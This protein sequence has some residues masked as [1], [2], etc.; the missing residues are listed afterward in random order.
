MLYA[1]DDLGGWGSGNVAFTWQEYS[2]QRSNDYHTIQER[3]TISL[4]P[5]S[6]FVD[7]VG[8]NVQS[9]SPQVTRGGAPVVSFDSPASTTHRFGWTL[10]YHDYTYRNSHPS[11]TS[12]SSG[13]GGL[14]LI[15]NLPIPILPLTLGSAGLWTAIMSVFLLTASELI[16]PLY[17][18][19][20]VLINRKRL[21]IAAFVLV[22]IFLISTAYQIFASQAL[23][24]K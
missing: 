5:G 21:R 2:W 10:F 17:S 20:G 19:T 1:L 18:K 8:S 24:S 23:I 7:I 4:P 12:N 9:L 15:S 13:N 16:S 14:A 11:P 6:T 22:S 3:F